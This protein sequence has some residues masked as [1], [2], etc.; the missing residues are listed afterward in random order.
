MKDGGHVV[1]HYLMQSRAIDIPPAVDWAAY[2]AVVVHITLRH[3][4]WQASDHSHDLLHTRAMSDAAYAD[5]VEA[6]FAGVSS[7]ISKVSQ[8]VG[9]AVPVFWLSFAEPTSTYQ[10]VLL[11]NRRKSLYHIVRTLNDE[12]AA[13][14]EPQANA[15]YLEIN[16]LIRYHGDGVVSDVHLRHFTHAGFLATSDALAIYDSILARVADAITVLRAVSPVKLIV[17]DLDNT[18]WKGVLAEYDTIVQH[19]HIEGWPLAY[20]EGLLEFKRRGGLLA[21]SSKNDHAA[22]LE[23]FRRLWDKRLSI[24]DFCSVKINWNPKSGNIQE[25]LA[26]TNLLPGNVLFIDDNPREIEEVTR[27]FPDMR[28]LSGDPLAWRNVILYSPH[29]QVARISDE[30]ASRTVLLQ[31]KQKRDRLATEM[32]RDSYLKS[33]DIRVQIEVVGEASHPKFARAAELVNKTNQFNTT[34]RRWS[35]GDFDDLFAC[36]GQIVALSAADRFGD[37][38]LVAVAVVRANEITQVV[39]SCRVFGFG[40]ETA[41]LHEA[42][43]RIRETAHHA[44][45]VASLVDTGKNMTCACYYRDNGFTQTENAGSWRAAGMPTVPAWIAF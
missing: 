19:Q 32:D 18:L 34:G 4:M 45:I 30:S 5:V 2:D 17:T 14:L 1:D 21:I 13:L 10:G 37:N 42:M 23:R 31:A 38:G 40:L 12:M 22:T 20:V 15:H 43:R 29:T 16:D 36:R 9:A 24:D 3:V 6:A 44:P 8:A 27:V 7:V 26:E 11:N 28:T 35:Q 39:M 33:L 41:L 25:I